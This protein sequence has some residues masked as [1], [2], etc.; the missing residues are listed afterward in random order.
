MID[1]IRLGNV[2]ID[3]DDEELLCS[4]YG[5]LLGWRRGSR[6]VISFN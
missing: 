3:C 6:R 5:A 2:M 1:E 4:F